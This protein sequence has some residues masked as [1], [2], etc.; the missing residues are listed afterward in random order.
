MTLALAIN[1]CVNL[2]VGWA[3]LL[4]W[5]SDR[6]QM[7]SRDLGWAFASQAMIPAAYL[8]QA[9]NQGV[10]AA[11]G[12]VVIV[13]VSALYLTLLLLGS[14]RLAGR[15]PT[16]VQ[17]FALG[18]VLLLVAV[19]DELILV[20]RGQRPSYVVAAE[21]RHAQGDFSSDI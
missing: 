18:A 14:A 19:L 3:L 16:R 5:R 15:V 13:G 20:L 4:A 9:Q 2:I 21:E 6:A 8:M 1:A 11:L 17:G 10:V 7:F 12:T